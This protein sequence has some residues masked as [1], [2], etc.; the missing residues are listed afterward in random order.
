MAMRKLKD[1]I[2]TGEFEIIDEF[3]CQYVE[4]LPRD[5]AV[6]KYGECEVWQQ[7]TS[8]D[9]QIP[10]GNGNVPSWKTDVWVQIPG[11][12]IGY[13]NRSPN[14]HL[15]FCGD[16][17]EATFIGKKSGQLIT[18]YKYGPDDYSAA[19]CDPSEKGMETRGCSVR[20]TAAQII[21]EIKEE[22]EG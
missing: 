7:Y 16:Q 20:G 22:W 14:L 5:K 21:E 3:N 9:S 12:K 10:D 2:T 11:M 13:G 4:T 1:F 8:G 6:A 18:V 19:F 15:F 17:T